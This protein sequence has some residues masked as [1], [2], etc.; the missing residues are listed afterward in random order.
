MSNAKKMPGAGYYELL[1]NIKHPLRVFAQPFAFHSVFQRQGK[2][3]IH[4]L[5]EILRGPGTA[6]ENFILQQRM[7]LM[8]QG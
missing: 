2:H 4:T 3:F 5:F 6:K 7:A 8:P 1:T